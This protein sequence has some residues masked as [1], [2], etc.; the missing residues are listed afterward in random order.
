MSK[1]AKIFIGVDPNGCDI[2]SQ[3]VLEWSLRKHSS[4]DVEIEWMMLSRDPNSFWYS[5]G[6]G[7]EGWNTT[8][9][10]TC[11]S[12][13]RWGIPARCNFEGKAIYMD[14][15]MIIL[16]DIQNLWDQ[17]FGGKAIIAKGPTMPDRFCVALMDNE[18]MGQILPPI[19]EIKRSPDMYQRIT[20]GLARQTHEFVQ[21]FI[22]NWNCVDGENLPLEQISIFHHSSMEHQLC[23]KYSIPRLRSEGRQHWYTGNITEHPRK[24]ARK[25]FDDLLDEAINNGFG[26]EK[27]S[28]PD[29]MKYGTYKKA[30]QNFSGNA[31]PYIGVNNG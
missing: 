18:K 10:A 15:D 23:H 5:S 6:D 30:Y 14:S 3:S 20:G 7:L 25:L 29:Y 22:G 13:F 11:F 1:K 26:P 2:E 8:N 21:P 17:D 27:Y 4:I 9:W 12:A 24:D 16:D 28:V 31:N 19:E